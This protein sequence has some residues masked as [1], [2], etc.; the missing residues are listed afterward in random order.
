[1]LEALIVL[2]VGVGLLILLPLLLLKLLFGLLFAVVV[3]PFKLLGAV[4]HTG[5]A[6]VGGLAKL[7]ALGGGLLLGI[8]GLLLLLALLPLLP[9]IALGVFIYLII[10][11]F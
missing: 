6:V 10:R 1:M 7:V 9:V 4:F 3:L 2:A 5:F 8:F 11:I